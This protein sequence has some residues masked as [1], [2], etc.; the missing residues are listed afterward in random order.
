MRQYI[1]HILL[2]ILVFGF[3]GCSTNKNTWLSRNYQALNT[4]YNVYFNGNESY[5]DG[6]NNILKSNVDDYS[7]ILPLYPIS[8]HSNASFA[9]S[10]MN[11]AIEKSQKA[12]KLHSIKK[13][14]QKDPHRLKDPKF[15]AF[16]KQEEYNPQI[17]EAWMLMGK[18][19]FHKTDFL[20]AVGTFSYV[21]KHFSWNKGCV[22]EARIWLARSYSEMGWEY[23]ADDALNKANRDQVPMR[24]TALFSA[25]KAD[26]LLKEKKYKEAI[27][28]LA[29]AA[30]QEKNKSQ[31]TRFNFVLAQL[32][33]LN[34]DDPKA[35]YYYGK[36][37]RASPPFEMELAARVNRAEAN[38]A[39]TDKSVRTLQRMLKNSKYDNY[40]DKIYYTIGLIYQEQAQTD[41][42]I[43]NYKWAIAK[44]KKGGEDKVAALVALADLYYAQSKYLD[45]QPYYAEASSLMLLDNPDYKRVNKR[46]QLLGELNQQ[47]EIVVLQDSLQAL[48]ALS[49]TEKDKQITTLIKKMQKEEQESKQKME[50]EINAQNAMIAQ[51]MEMQSGK[52]EAAQS[53]GNWYFYNNMLVAGGKSDFQKRWGNRKLEDNWRR[54]NK[55]IVENTETTQSTADAAAGGD[56]SNSLV[57]ADEQ[58]KDASSVITDKQYYLKQ[59]P[60]TESQMKASNDQIASAL[61][62][63]LN[64]YNDDLEDS[65]MAIKTLDELERRFPNDKNLPDAYYSLYQTCLKKNDTT[66]AD[67]Y[68]MQL[69]NKFPETTYAKALS[70][71]DFSL[72]MK[73]MYL[74]QDS[75]Y[76]ESYFAYSRSEYQTVF[77]NYKEV[78]E[79]Y[80]LTTLMPK[81]M[82]VNALS[83]G[84]FG[85]KEE[86]QSE[87]QLLVK[88]YPQSDVSP[89]AKDILALIKQGN[90]V[91]QGS[92]HGAIM[93]LRDS[94]NITI[95]LSKDSMMFS[96][97]TREKHFIVVVVP[98]D[99]DIN[100][101]QFNIASYNFTGF[102]VKDFDIEV[103]KYGNDTRLLVISA[104][105]DLDEAQWYL[106]GM[107][108]NQDIQLYLKTRD[109]Y[110][111]IVSETN[112]AMIKKGR[113]ISDYLSYYNTNI[114]MNPSTTEAEVLPSGSSDQKSAEANN[115][116]EAVV[117]QKGQDTIS[118]NTINNNIKKSVST[119]TTANKQ[120]IPAETVAQP[121]QFSASIDEPHAF[122]IVVT[123]G[124]IDYNKLKAVFDDYNAKNYTVANLKINMID[125]GEQKL[126]YVSMFTDANAARTY[127]FGAIRNRELFEPL[128]G[129]EFRKVIISEKNI[130]VLSKTKAFTQY[131][132]FNRVNYMK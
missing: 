26:L 10:Q 33:R 53:Q 31:R 44:S 94:A 24:L 29:I 77:D 105:D 106:N 73:E 36:V 4:R 39:N 58:A 67:M 20:A 42:A 38:R 126:I 86:L 91:Q 1:Q 68:R 25:T 118:V 35:V 8:N 110:T 131:F 32:Y 119:D 85:K 54:K 123:T 7:T 14:P 128:Q 60:V 21:I 62:K 103:Q 75:L 78:K 47:H 70:Q 109:C 115:P 93:N 66:K 9:T 23:E 130:D 113:T 111:F 102:L 76:R 98:K 22:S 132:T 43:Q 114:E 5:K 90:E 27:P 99:M 30:D 3:V 16:L 63:M 83:L 82:F 129:S 64:I 57:Q 50:A 61:Y 19:Q 34:G 74:V 6:V 59:L 127:L 124:N 37:K 97:N 116:D 11:R 12:I 81:F 2:G 89:M 17:D 101:L 13:K 96:P 84:K 45:S 107:K 41:K 100:K 104:L 40:Q 51:E 46:S 55:A 69:V 52:S 88:D 122:A 49:D 120:H 71:P 79:K 72:K 95:C 117:A 15:Q 125:L 80:P 87:L 112:F 48:A 18:A 121:V 65:P 28:Y 108:N 56:K 92:S